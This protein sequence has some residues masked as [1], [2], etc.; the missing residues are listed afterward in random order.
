MRDILKDA[1]SALNSSWLVFYLMPGVVSI[2]IFLY[3]W[4]SEKDFCL[5]NGIIETIGIFAA[6]M[7]TLIF[8]IVDHFVKRKETRN[9]LDDEEK[10]YIARYR[11]FAQN[12]VAMISFSILLAGGIILLQI[13]LPQ[14]KVECSLVNAI[15]N[16]VFAFFLIQYAVLILLIIKEM[17]AMLTDDI[18]S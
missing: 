8:V 15:T 3:L 14:I 9:G 10:N 12:S 7:F 4:I 17:Y 2:G 13:I 11:E 5:Y 1:F 18:E 16:S 6:F